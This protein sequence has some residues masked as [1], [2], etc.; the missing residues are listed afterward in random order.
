[1]HK[2]A[3]RVLTALTLVAWL[4]VPATHAQSIMLKA[5]VP[6]NF[7]VGDTQLPSGEY[8]VKQL[9]PGVIQVQDKVTRSSAIVMTTGVQAG[10]TSD[11][12]KLVFNRYGDNYFLS[13]IWEPSSIIGRQLPKSRLEREVAVNFA[14]G[15]T[16]VAAVPVRK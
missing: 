6:F 11:V 1:M 8:H 7:V 16:T 9:R 4:M 3:N 5:D 13:R 14:L 2:Y 10:K 15:Q 12:G